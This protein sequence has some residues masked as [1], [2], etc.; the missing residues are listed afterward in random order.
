MFN[1]KTRNISLR[2][3]PFI[4]LIKKKTLIRS[5]IPL[6]TAK[7]SQYNQEQ[8]INSKQIKQVKRLEKIN[9]R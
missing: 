8:K 3:A 1:D 7:N 4:T 5:A 9:I 2:H 6:S